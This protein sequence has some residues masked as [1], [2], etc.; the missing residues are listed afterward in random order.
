MDFREAQQLATKIASG[1]Y[2]QGELDRLLSFM[3]MADSE[4]VSQLLDVYRDSLDNLNRKD[5]QVAPDFMDRLR[6]LRPETKKKI[7]WLRW[8]SVA[9]SILL[10]FGIYFY[11]S[12]KNERLP[13]VAQ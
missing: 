6:A 10:V 1:E 4:Q 9:A 12:N 5:L 11:F 3:E 13:V 2:N 7:N 8:A